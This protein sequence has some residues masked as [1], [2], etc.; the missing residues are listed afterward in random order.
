MI[1]FDFYCIESFMVTTKTNRTIYFDKGVKY[2]FE[3]MEPMWYKYVRILPRDTYLFDKVL[4]DKKFST[5][6]EWRDRIIG[7]LL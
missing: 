2:R 6:E 5:I 1:F 4:I 7:E 3:Y